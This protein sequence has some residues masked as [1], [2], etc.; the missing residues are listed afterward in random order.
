MIKEVQKIS[1]SGYNAQ[2]DRFRKA[3]NFSQKKEKKESTSF[4]AIL[5]AA[6]KKYN[7]NI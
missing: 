4:A 2:Y 1:F 7:A 6:S 3:A 5:E